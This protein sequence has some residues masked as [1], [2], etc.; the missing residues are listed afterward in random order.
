MVNPSCPYDDSMMFI[1]IQL[2][3]YD[4]T[5]KYYLTYHYITYKHYSTFYCYFFSHNKINIEG[6][7]NESKR[8]NYIIISC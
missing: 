7:R 6:V 4:I 8:Y 1:L 3:S 5:Y 2:V